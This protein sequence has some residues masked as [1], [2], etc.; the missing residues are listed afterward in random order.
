MGKFELEKSIQSW[1]KGF[2]KHRAF[3]DG[4]LQEMEVHLRDHI[5]DL[6]ADGYNPEDAFRKATAS[7]GESD[8]VAREEYWNHERGPSIRKW[9]FAAMLKNY[10]RTSLRTML[11]NPLTTFINVF[12]LA[13]AIGSTMVVYSFYEYD[14]RI[15]QFHEHKHEVFLV[16]NYVNRD[17][18]LAQYG[19]SPAPIGERFTNDFPGVYSMTRV[20]DDRAVVKSDEEVYHESVRLVDPDFLEMFTFPLSRGDRK[21]LRDPNTIIISADMAEKY[22][23]HVDPI[24]QELKVIFS[25]GTSKT[26]QVGGIAEEFPLERTISFDFLINFENIVTVA[27]DFNV[28]DWG[29]EVAATFIHLSDPSEINDMSQLLSGY[30]EA[31]RQANPDWPV[32]AFNFVSLAELHQRSGFIEKD[33]SHDYNAEARLGMPIIAGLMMILACLNYI[34]IAMTSAVKRLK[35]IGLRKVIGA[36]RGQLVLQFLSENVVMTLFALAL[37]LI[38]AMAIFIPWFIDLSG[39]PLK[40]NLLDPYLWLFSAAIVLLTGIVSGLYPAIYISRYQ[41]VQ[42]FDGR[43][44]FGKKSLVTKLFLGLQ[45]IITCSSITCAII[46]TQNNEFQHS[47]PWGYDQELAVYAQAPDA[48]GARQLQTAMLQSAGVTNT[49]LSKNHIGTSYENAIIHFP[50]REYEVELLEV[51]D[52]YLSVMGISLKSGRD[53]LPDVA[54]ERQSVIVNETMVDRLALNDALA[55]QFEMNGTKYKIIGVMEDFHSYNFFYG[56]EPMMIALAAPE[57]MQFVTLKTNA[58]NRASVYEELQDHWLELF[59]ETPFQGAYQEDTWTGFFDQLYS[60]E[61]FYK[62]LAIIAIMLAGMG[63]YGLVTLNVTS[64]VREFSIRKVLGAGVGHLAS[65]VGNQYLVL[66]LVSL[67]IGVPF[68]Y[69]IGVAAMEM[70]FA[71]PMPMTVSGLVLAVVIMI[72]VVLLV[73]STQIRNVLKSNPVTGLRAE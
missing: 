40:L 23:A 2:R 55:T 63:L 3:D 49:T 53:F 58:I 19:T 7:F 48:K 59:P 16:T 39:D 66:F 73:V 20:L 26:F 38:L 13:V 25:S 24:G 22:F 4:H 1:L 21:S 31:Q 45:L 33:I 70:L 62:A 36:N 32:E 60:A 43:L 42:I 28:D 65:S 15:D 71:Y 52:Q 35:E 41:S 56:I 6:T 12:G 72:F 8:K 50:D 5:D 68:S 18:T 27:P 17:G 44:R 64:R 34:N 37:G 57:T 14:Q 61:R 46:F 11:R 69:W 47:R 51:D 9:L 30:Q 54:S 10:Y 29:I 67:I